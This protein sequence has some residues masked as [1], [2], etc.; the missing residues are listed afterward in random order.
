MTLKSL[1]QY[2]NVLLCSSLILVIMTIYPPWRISFQAG[3]RIMTQPYGWAYLFDPP[4]AP[5]EWTTGYKWEPIPPGA[6][7]EKIE[8]GRLIIEQTLPPERYRT[9]WDK[10]VFALNIDFQILILEWLSVIFVTMGVI[11][12]I[13]R[14]EYYERIEGES[15]P[16]KPDKYRH[17]VNPMIKIGGAF[18]C[19]LIIYTLAKE[20]FPALVGLR[21][22]ISVAG[23]YWLMRIWESAKAKRDGKS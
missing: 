19:V 20:A 21:I 15:V 6:D 8:I 11:F 1:L 7:R 4:E 10:R 17:D 12:V 3:N 2:R 13:S 5:D 18:F 16:K 23:F 14:V 22:V 9:P